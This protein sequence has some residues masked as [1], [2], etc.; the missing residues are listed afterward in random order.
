MS[1][2]LSKPKY[3]KFDFDLSDYDDEYG[4]VRLP[5]SDVGGKKILF[6]LDYMP[7]E[8]LASGR[9][10]SGGT[11]DL[12]RNLLDC[13][14]EFFLKKKVRFSWMACTFNA[15]KTAGRSKEFKDNANR[16]FEERLATIILRYKPDMI[17]SFGDRPSRFLLP[18]NVGLT[19]GRVFSWYGVPCEAQVSIKKK[20]HE[21]LVTPTLGLNPMV[22][23]AKE[24]GKE[25]MEATYLLGYV[26]RN[27]ANALNFGL[28]WKVP[29]S[30]RLDQHKA[31]L[32]DTVKKFDKLMDMLGQEKNISIDTEGKNLNKVTN[33]VYTIQFAKCLRYG[34]V[35]PLNHADSP[36][37]GKEL[38]YIKSRLAAFFEGDND[39]ETHIYT[40][41]KFDLNVLRVELNT[42]FMANS[43]WDIQAGEFVLD[44]N[45]KFLAAF[46]GDKKGYY[47]LDNLAVQ[48]G[49]HGYLTAEFSKKD[50]GN[51]NVPLTKPV[52]H[53]M[54]SDV[55]VPLAIFNLQKKQ[56]E[57]VGHK[58]Y[59]SV[60]SE[61]LSDLIHVISRMEVNGSGVDVDWLFYLKAPGSPIEGELQ[62]VKSEANKL[63]TVKKAN[64]RLLKIKGIQK[65]GLFGDRETIF[66]LGHPSH[67][68]VLFFDVLDLDPVSVSKSGKGSLGKSFQKKYADVPEV[69]A[70]ANLS[71]VAKLKNAFVTAFIKRLG[72]DEDMKKDLRIRPSYG[73][74]PVV[75]GRISAEKPSLHQIPS[76]GELGKN[77]KRIFVAREGCL[78]IKVDYRVHEVRGWAIISFDKALAAVFNQASALV[79]E[80]KL[81]P[82]KKLADRISLEA[83][84]HKINANYFYKIP[85]KDI[86]KDIRNSIKNVVFGLIYQ[87]AI[88]SLARD[89]G[90]TEEF[91]R[92]LVEKFFG[93]FPTGTKW[94]ENIKRFARKHLFVENPL[95]LRR[96]LWGYLV[97]DSLEKWAWRVHSDMDRRAVNS[98]IQGMGSQFQ[99]IGARQ[100]DIMVHDLWVTSKRRVRMWVNNS[101][102]DSLETEWSYEDLMLGLDYM[103]RALTEKVQEVCMKRHGMKFVA[104]LEVDFEIGP[105][106]KDCKD[107]DFSAERLESIVKESLE[108]QRDKLNRDVDVG[109]TMEVI[110]SKRRDMPRWLRTQIKNL[111][112]QFEYEKPIKKKRKAA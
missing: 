68:Q 44:E 34:Y 32:I 27:L 42:K 41:A 72:F 92:D 1:A 75:T 25:M 58:K 28:M 110:F 108:F 76:R 97:P 40:N 106:L 8:D 104:P 74:L 33:R 22:T 52:L 63:E 102:H 71:K 88:K 31:V 36:F 19:E 13:A 11:G 105:T 80:F 70:L 99:N 101:V 69:Q 47:G 103:E 37:Y 66:D 23:G 26:A 43:I 84:V 55:V 61:Q 86:T 14:S 78:Y 39:N 100:L 59:N 82:S 54:A 16:V 81:R 49:Y 18:K 45:R 90:R 20:V 51:M 15:F 21:C 3:F 24:S 109:K 38:K 6:V 62:R 48:Y 57:F 64:D 17:I 112:Y 9:L 95:G 50:R 94:I 5:Y 30:V 91:T 79:N 83:D 85:F 10:L 35:V 12:L 107:W 46:T 89:L 87:M 96:Y 60:V 93:R 111:D 53:Y 7:T 67:Q 98:P 73:F 4:Y 29:E 77:I 2:F 56:G 65:K